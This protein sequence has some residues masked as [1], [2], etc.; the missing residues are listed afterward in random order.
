M[1]PNKLQTLFLAEVSRLQD[2]HEAKL[3]RLMNA[4]KEFKQGLELVELLHRLGAPDDFEM[5]ASHGEDAFYLRCY[6]HH[7][8]NA[9]A[10]LAAIHGSRLPFS[11][12]M[13]YS[14]DIRLV[15][16]EGYAV[17]IAFKA[18]TVIPLQEAA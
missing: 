15:A 7:S 18:D 8:V 17:D 4:Q 6:A 2:Q 12:G 1:S 10:V 9:E 16:V 13:G 11:I 3:Q 5:T 14:D